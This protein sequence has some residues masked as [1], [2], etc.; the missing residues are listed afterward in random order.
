[1][2]CKHIDIGG[3]EYLWH[4]AAN[5]RHAHPVL[6]T[7]A[8]NQRL[9]FGSADAIANEAQLVVLRQF[10]HG[11]DGTILVLLRAECCHHHY[12]HIAIGYEWKVVELFPPVIVVLD[13]QQTVARTQF[14]F[15]LQYLVAYTLIKLIGSHV[16]ARHDDRLVK[17]LAMITR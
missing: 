1:M 2:R 14:F 5:A 8:R 17:S 9:N 12:H 7:E 15:T 13:H 3:L 11:S 16:A 6:Q 4:I 10:R